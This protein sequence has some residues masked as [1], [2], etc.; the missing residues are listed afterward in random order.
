MDEEAIKKMIKDY[1]FDGIAADMAFRLASEVERE[2]RHNYFRLMQNANNAA[3]SREITARELDKFVWDK[4]RERLAAKDN[5]TLNNEACDSERKLCSRG[6]HRIVEDDC[7]SAICVKC[8]K[9]FGW[10]CQI[11]TKHF[12]E[13][14][15][16][17][18]CIHCGAPEERQ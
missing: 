7:G 9:D 6:E 8:N 3:S 1:G 11:S 17:E 2:T 18:A 14:A 16:D 15:D 5:A 12:C 10:Y 4:S 13:Y